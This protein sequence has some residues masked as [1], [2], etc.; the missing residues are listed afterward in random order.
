MALYSGISIFQIPRDQQILSEIL[1][2][3]VIEG[4][5]TGILCD[6]DFKSTLKIEYFEIPKFE[7][8]S[9][10]CIDMVSAHCMDLLSCS[11]VDGWTSALCVF[12]GGCYVM[13]FM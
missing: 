11:S 2:L 4:E 6:R 1:R 3:S 13:L 8:L 10:Y 12:M 5:N 7:L 9:F